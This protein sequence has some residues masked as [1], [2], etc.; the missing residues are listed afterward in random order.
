M[1]RYTSFHSLAFPLLSYWS[2]D[3]EIL[4]GSLPARTWREAAEMFA[5]FEAPH[6]AGLVHFT[7]SMPKG[8]SLSDAIW[9]EVIDHVM[10]KS[11]LPT[12]LVPWVAWGGEKT[13]C[14][15]IH[16]A[17]ACE[18]FLG[19]ELELQ[20]SLKATDRLERDLRQRLSL[21]DLPWRHDP[22][23][24]LAPTISKRN[25]V[26]HGQ[27]GWFASDLNAA[28]RQKRPS[29]LTNLNLALEENG[30]AWRVTTSPERADLLV[31]TNLLTGRSCNPRRAGAAFRSSL[32]LQRFALAARLRAIAFS[33]FLH[34]VADHIRDAL[35]TFLQTQGKQYERAS[36]GPQPEPHQNRQNEG[37]CS[38]AASTLTASRPSPRGADIGIRG[39]PPELTSRAAKGTGG[40]Q[41]HTGSYRPDPGRIEPS[42]SPT[43]AQHRVSFGRGRSRASRV[44]AIYR[45]A[46]RAGIK[47]KHRFVSNHTA[48]LV[49]GPHG[50]LVTNDLVD[51]T[52]IE[53]VENPCPGWAQF[54]CELEQIPG[55]WKRELGT[56]SENERP[57]VF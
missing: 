9:F 11:G 36:V 43:G 13:S 3:G 15:H 1:R 33:L 12:T 18:T 19:R 41:S 34:R 17:S 35:P 38:E 2:K 23:L 47:I 37:G 57:T 20:T 7:L 16:I 44:I 46:K 27:D 26:K 8:R 29:S 5:P 32:I 4:T 52:L 42:L 31:P 24:V 55:C 30:S 48:V 51:G 6:G 22:A 39:A 45:A 56:A 25:R 14:D 50:E 40:Q 49:S 21:P 53:N 10:T 54:V 28:M